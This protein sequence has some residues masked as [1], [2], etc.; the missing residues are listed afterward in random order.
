MDGEDGADVDVDVDV[1]GAVERVE[2]DDVAAGFG[3]G[4]DDDGLFVLFAD[5]RGDGVTAAEDVKK[6]FVGVD[7]E[8]LLDFALDVD[9]ALGAERVAEAAEADFGF[10]H[11]CGEGEAAE[12]P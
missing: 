9:G 7:V 6:H 1:G 5:E 11:F 3:V 10:D 4:V 2:D 12:Q 8:L